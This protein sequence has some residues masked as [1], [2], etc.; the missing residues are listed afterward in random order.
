MRRQKKFTQHFLKLSKEH[1][2]IEKHIERM[3]NE[4]NGRPC[5]GP[6]FDLLEA[7]CEDMAQ[8][9]AMEE[10]VLFPAA[11]M[12]LRDLDTVDTVLTLS[13]EHGYYER[14]LATLRLNLTAQEPESALSKDD[15]FTII[16]ILQSLKHHARLEMD[17]LFRAMDES[18]D[19]NKILKGFISD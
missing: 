2:I 5:C 9:F 6:V 7:F 4:L 3:E 13:K 1:I 10:E 8:H 12:G 19:C 16:H 18:R 15:Q 17:T 11:L 14:D